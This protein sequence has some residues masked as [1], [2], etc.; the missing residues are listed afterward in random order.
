MIFTALYFA[1]SVIF[2]VGAIYSRLL[3]VII[4]GGSAVYFIKVFLN[5]RYIT[6]TVKIWT[7]F[8]LVNTLFFIFTGDFN[9]I[10]D[11]NIY[12][13]VLLNFLPF[14][15]FYYFAKKKILTKKILLLFFAIALPLF[16]MQFIDSLTTLQIE[17]NREDVVSNAI[18]IFIGLLPFAFFFK[19]KLLSVASLLLIWFFMVQSNK[20]AAIVAGIFAILIFIYQTFFVSKFKYKIHTFF[21]GLFVL[22]GVTY[23]GIKVY[24]E[25]EFLQ[26]RMKL[27]FSGDL[28]GRDRI[29]DTHF[30]TWYYSDSFSTLFFGLGY[31]SS[32]R[33]VDLAAHND[34]MDMLGSFGLFGLFIY[35]LLWYYVTNEIFTGNWDKNKKVIM[36]LYLGLSFMASQFFRWYC[37]PFSFMNYMILP[38]LIANKNEPIFITNP[39]K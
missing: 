4:L 39:S 35:L 9:N 6:N 7:V 10:S 16:I 31:N 20:R 13:T 33:L 5:R 11:F 34:W 21:I 26:Y 38:Y 12:K 1:Q 27:A 37:S 36:I 24:E 28:S 14:Y 2:G 3:L 18:Y 19:N 8:L 23:V 30:N 29:I 32:S 15:A 22:I 17:R 25:N